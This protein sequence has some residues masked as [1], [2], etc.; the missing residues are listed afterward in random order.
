MRPGEE[1][2]E[3]GGVK[4]LALYPYEGAFRERLYALKGLRDIE[5]AGVFLAYQAALLGFIYRGYEVVPA[6]SYKGH[7]EE[8]GY[9][10]VVEAFRPLG[11]PIIEALEKKDDVKQAGSS[12]HKRQEIGKHIGLRENIDLGGKKI[13]FVDD[14]FTTGATARACLKIL[15]SLGP[16]S[17]KA[18]FLARTSGKTPQKGDIEDGNGVFA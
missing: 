3:V 14:V 15:S 7:D 17:L 12:A 11:L 9:N 16:K 10:H 6:P 5:M 8:R 13:L 18:L 4:A 1:R 2:F